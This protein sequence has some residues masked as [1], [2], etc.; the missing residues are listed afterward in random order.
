MRATDNA[1]VIHIR[2]NY[3][4]GE[5][6]ERFERGF[7]QASHA[8]QQRLDQQQAQN[9]HSQG[10]LLLVEAAA[11]RPGHQWLGQQRDQHTGDQKGDQ[12]HIQDVAGQPPGIL[13]ALLGQEAG[14]DR[15]ERRA[16]RA[17]S[18]YQVD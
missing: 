8:Q 11:D 3:R 2:A 15:D 13:L 7:R 12:H 6:I 10:A 17:A 9:M 5:A 1:E 16:K 18:D 14:E 4:Q